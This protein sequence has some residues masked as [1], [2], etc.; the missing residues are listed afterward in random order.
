MHSHNNFEI[1]KEEKLLVS[2]LI[3]LDFIRKGK[4]ISSFVLK[5]I[6]NRSCGGSDASNYWSWK[7][8]YEAVEM[9]KILHIQSLPLQDNK[10]P[11]LTELHIQDF[12][13]RLPTQTRR[14]KEQIELQMFSTP[15]TIG[16]LAFLAASITPEDI[17]LE[18]SAGT[19]M[20]ASF[21]LYVASKI[22]L[23]ELQSD[24]INILKLLYPGSTVTNHN[25][26]QIND[27]LPLDVDPTIILMNPPFTARRFQSKSS[28]GLFQ[29][30]K[31]ALLRLKTNGRLVIISQE[32]ANPT[33]SL[34]WRNRFIELQSMATA[35]GS[36]GIEGKAYYKHGTTLDTRLTV[37]EK[38][39]AD[40]PQDFGKVH[41]IMDLEELLARVVDLP[42]RKPLST[43]EPKDDK[44][45]VL[46]SRREKR[47]EQTST[48][49]ESK[50]SHK[51]RAISKVNW[52]KIVDV[53]Y[54]VKEDQF[55]SKAENEIYA[56]Y[57]PHIAIANG[58]AHPTPLVESVAM[59]SIIPPVPTYIPRLP[60]QIIT[61]GILSKAQLETV[62]RA[63][64]AHSKFLGRYVKLERE[65]PQYYDYP[66]DGSNNLRQG[67]FLGDGTGCGKGR[68]IAGII[69][70]NWLKGK[71]KAIWITISPKLIEDTK[72]DWQALGGNPDNIINLAKF[73]QGNTIE[74]TKGILF[75][76]YA[77]LRISAKKD[78]MSRVE[79]IVEWLGE[80]FDGVIGFDE[81]HAMAG[82]IGVESERGTTKASKQGIAGMLLQNMLP[83]ARVVYASATGASQLSN[84]AYAGR[85]G[86]WGTKQFP[87]SDEWDFISLVEQGG[88][89][90][91]EIVCRDLKAYGLYLARSISYTGVKYRT[92]K[93]EL[94][95]EQIE[96]YDTYSHAYQQIHHHLTEALSSTNQKLDRQRSSNAISVF[97]T[98]KQR[99]FNQLLTSMKMP[100]LIADI[101]RN[102]CAGKAIVIQL[103]STNEA[104][105]KRKLAEIPVSEWEDLHADFTPREYLLEYLKDS[106]PI[107]LME[108]HEEDG[109]RIV[110]KA[111]DKDGNPILN[112]KAI[113]IRD[114]A[115][116][117]ILTLPQIQ[118]AL[119]QI[120][121]HFGHDSVAEVTGRRYRIIEEKGKRKVDTRPSQANLAEI[122]Q[123]M[124]GKKQILVFSD[125]GGTGSSYH[126]D[127]NCQNQLQRIHYIL[128]A[129]WSATKAIQSAGRSH[130]SN[131]VI[132]P[133]FVVVTTN[134]KGEIRFSSTIAS[135]L[136]SLGALTKGQSQT[137]SQGL[138]DEARDLSSKYAW[139][140]LQR[141]YEEICNDSLHL[142]NY[143][144]FFKITALDLLHKDGT[145]TKDLPPMNRFMNR[146]LACPIDL[147]NY[148]FQRLETLIDYEIERAK[149]EG[150]Y[151]TGIEMIKA[152][153][154][155]VVETKQL[156]QDPNTNT[157]TLCHKIERHDKNKIND[158]QYAC[159]V[160]KL[161]EGRRVINTK[162]KN[163]AIAVLGNSFTDSNTGQEERIIDLIRPKGTSKMSSNSFDASCWEDVDSQT[164]SIYWQEEVDKLPK[165]TVSY[166]YLISGLLLPIWDKFSRSNLKIWRIEPENSTPILGRK[167]QA[168]QIAKVYETFKLDAIQLKP[169]EIIEAIEQDNIAIKLI[170]DLKIKK[171]KIMGEDRYEIID[172]NRQNIDKLEHCGC[173]SEI[174]Y[175]SLRVFVPV[176]QASKVI[177][178]IYYL[179][180]IAC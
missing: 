16:Y 175:S 125:A 112:Q 128:E 176:E 31:S 135:R 103:V 154:L 95:K 20:L 13:S 146:L 108:V 25:A 148:L 120:I 89:S 62:I 60:E 48:E 50:R 166:F 51:V 83:K 145:M 149:K 64:E 36:F 110:Q 171:S 142:C 8:A 136:S 160:I 12:E 21:A 79:Q 134:V 71:T 35:I 57:E 174:I 111:L 129:G 143:A 61:E 5:N 161:R 34:L 73:K 85:L 78:K 32:S 164:W 46:A 140:G 98:S 65:K 158:F 69:L 27:R 24:R 177:E 114:R 126:A 45:I 88:I 117:E 52:Q 53:S 10:S 123:F 180:N 75:L 153:K 152:L 84:L 170:D 19:G 101:E 137:G 1:D 44:V 113:E 121:Q 104:V 133:E 115:I 7:E 131:Q 106:F 17:V 76:T 63:G 56:C 70:D 30:L 156:W 58:Q 82:A 54:T 74:A 15:A 150:I 144:T 2:A 172:W 127:K 33:S 59:S 22:Y 3:I 130:R 91:L 87:F 47:Y 159:R 77:Q 138:F 141:L 80:D 132:A 40:N 178:R 26:E 124:S 72:R 168:G 81:S 139:Q 93:Q 116:K 147:Q 18:P 118:T 49:Q 23:N 157:S 100:S 96:I 162:S 105:L 122:N 107:E 66:E 86:L 11:Y 155:N 37:W 173:F 163:V 169:T 39:P 43:T 179:N 68:Q 42:P 165:T 38:Y 92:L 97:E 41:P 109:F 55:T 119:D 6:M 67:F 28:D 94:T 151:N 29:H 4:K 102:R 90:A 14:S 99:F 167:I 9:A